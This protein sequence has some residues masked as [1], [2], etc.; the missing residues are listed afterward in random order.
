[1]SHNTCGLN[2]IL[3]AESKDRKKM[4][5][6]SLPKREREVVHRSFAPIRTVSGIMNMLLNRITEVGR[7]LWNSVV[8]PHFLSTGSTRVGCPGLCLVRFEESPR[9]ESLQL[10]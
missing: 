2:V 7:D 6:L 8:Q 1:M 4:F 5:F 3:K 10:L 9:T